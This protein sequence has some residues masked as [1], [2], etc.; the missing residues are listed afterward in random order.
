[1]LTL[2]GMRGRIYYGWLIV[3]VSVFG[4][5]TGP[6]LFLYSSLGL[7]VIPF[8]D[9][10]GW[11]RAQISLA[12]TVFT[13]V[14]AITIPFIGGLIDKFGSKNVLIPSVVFMIL[15]LLAI[16]LLIS[17]VWHLILIFGLISLLSAGAHSVPFMRIISTWFDHRRGLAIGIA[18]GGA[19]AS[20]M[21][22]PPLV[23]YM[24]DIHGWR[25]GYYSLAA[26]AFF[27]TLP[28][29]ILFLREPYT[30]DEV[31]DI[32]GKLKEKSDSI[33]S[34]MSISEAI[35][36]RE[37]WLLFVMFSLVSFCLYGIY[38]HFVPLLI[39]RGIDSRY[40]A[41]IASIIGATVIVARVSIGFLIDRIFAPYVAIL[42]FCATAIGIA[43]LAG[44]AMSS[45]AC[46]AA[47]F[48][49]F[50]MGVE[51]DLLAYLASR[52]FGLKSYGQI[53]GIL[54]V[55][56]LLG[57]SLGPVSYGLV[58]EKTGSYLWML[59]LSILL[60][61]FAAIS[62]AFLPKYPDKFSSR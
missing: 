25:Y 44:G 58:H 10:F 13:I 59:L 36:T 55:S 19:G 11:G 52:Y 42:C 26:L 48:I 3:A 16:P 21:Y 54:F 40:A 53:Y 29:I 47:I 50:S 15:G 23:Q 34:G 28:L 57:A 41:W 33:N 60:M 37:I 56:F 43:L 18:M 1:M 32:G 51:M 17:E 20:Y 31:K 14:L 12:S 24:I 27:T 8:G 30:Q 46:V 62:A 39:D 4:L 45:L 35:K 38:F 9:E 7:F 61:V 2:S 6:G 5:S 22:I 49:G